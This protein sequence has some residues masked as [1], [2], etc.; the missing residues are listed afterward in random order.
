METKEK[1]KKY[2]I[3]LGIMILLF[4][5]VVG[6][7]I[8]WGLGYIHFG[9]QAEVENNN[10]I[11][12][13]NV[14][15]PSDELQ[16]QNPVKD[17]KE[18]LKEAYKKYDFDW[19]SKK[20]DK[21][22]YIENGMIKIELG[23]KTYE[24]KFEYGEAVLVCD[25]QGQEFSG[26]VVLNDK[27]E[28]YKSSG[29]EYDTNGIL[30]SN[31]FTF[32]KL[33]LNEKIVDISRTGNLGAIPYSG[34]YYM[35]QTGKVIDSENKTYEEINKDHINIFGGLDYLTFICEDKTIDVGRT[36]GEYIKI[37]DGEG[38]PIKAKYA[39]NPNNGYEYKIVDEKDNYYSLLF[40]SN[41]VAYSENKKVKE[42][43]YDNDKLIVKVVFID[44]E[45]EQYENVYSVYDVENN[46]DM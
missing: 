34:P 11:S 29:A 7:A 33:D 31:T 10:D 19:V 8:A 3:T 2:S 46:K 12:S 42:I 17:N 23:E 9:K 39:I 37:V 38:N 13:E 26:I 5:I 27:G 44:S 16:A 41:G 28:I 15:K 35:T 21:L 14:N 6:I 4:L 45:A 22:T 1:D 40:S 24:V 32:T 30:K 18:L 20:K 43:D 36:D 25:K